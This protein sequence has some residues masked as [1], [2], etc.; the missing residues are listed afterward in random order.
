MEYKISIIVSIFNKEECLENTIQSVIKQTIGFENLELIL[1]DDDSTDDSRVIINNFARKYSNIKP[2]F[3]NKNCGLGQVRNIGI[4]NATSKYIMFLD[5]DDEYVEDIC[6]TLYEKIEET[7]VDLVGCNHITIDSNQSI[8][9]DYMIDE[10]IEEKYVTSNENIIKRVTVWN[11][12]HRK[13][14][15]KENNIKFESRVCEDFNFTA[16]EFA[17]MNAMIFLNNYHGYKYYFYDGS[18]SKVPSK[19]NIVN[20]IKAY[21]QALDNLKEINREDIFEYQINHQI[22]AFFSRIIHYDGSEVEKLELLDNL[23]DFEKYYGKKITVD[24]WPYDLVNKLVL[25]KQY[26]QAI[27]LLN[28][29]RIMRGGLMKIRKILSKV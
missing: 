17:H 23:Y 11:K 7:N 8:K 25:K 2:I 16:L 4:D 24:L 26:K 28:I 5:G 9:L 13:D 1:I 27:L 18:D 19:E 20:V 29:L 10:S 3:L 22:I 12:I 6:E 15:I 21:Y 14:F